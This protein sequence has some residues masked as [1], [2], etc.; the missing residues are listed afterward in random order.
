MPEHVRVNTNTLDSLGNTI[1]AVG[2]RKRKG[3]VVGSA[4]R[5]LQETGSGARNSAAKK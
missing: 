2:K 3:F 5:A 1:A 4:V